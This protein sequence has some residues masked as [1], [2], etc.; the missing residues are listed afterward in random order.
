MYVKYQFYIK[1]NLFCVICTV[2]IYYI[3]MEQMYCI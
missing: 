1:L 3:V 2:T